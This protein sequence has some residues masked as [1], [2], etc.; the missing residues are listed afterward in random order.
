MV[1]SWSRS[2]GQAHPLLGTQRGHRENWEFP[3]VTLQGL[4]GTYRH[5]PTPAQ[6]LRC[7]HL[8]VFEVTQQ[9]LWYEE[10][11]QDI[12]VT[13]PLQQKPP[14]LSF[15]ALT[16]ARP[17]Q[18]GQGGILVRV[19]LGEPCTMLFYTP[20]PSLSLCTARLLFSNAQQH[21]A[22]TSYCSYSLNQMQLHRATLI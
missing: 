18:E 4:P 11:K 22:I 12:C 2:C 6:R 10:T 20:I 9:L 7:T 15:Y 3:R 1:L 16:A 21:P 17:Q 8:K 13:L 5:C 19:L 14:L